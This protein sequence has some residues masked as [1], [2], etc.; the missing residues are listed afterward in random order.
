MAVDKVILK[1]VCSTLISIVLLFAFLF[2]SLCL[3]FPST[4]MRFTYDLGM[5][6][7]SVK[8]ATRAYKNSG[9][10]Y[11]IAYATEVSIGLGDADKIEKYGEKLLADE[12]FGAYCEMRNQSLP[13][14]TTMTYEQYVYGQVCMAL[15]EQGKKAEAV[16]RAFELIGNTFPKN[17]AAAAVLLAALRAQDTET[18]ELIKGKM[19]AIG[20]GLQG[21][22]KTYYDAILALING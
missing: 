21:E 10:V 5:D 8:F 3:F 17:N 20:N 9:E 19:L 1:A 16:E 4:M 14:D 13:E 15:Y 2:G 11:Y 18:V 6:E 12:K 22:D 7:S